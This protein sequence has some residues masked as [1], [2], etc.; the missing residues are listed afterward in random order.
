[1]PRMR[2]ISTINPPRVT[3]DTGKEVQR[4]MSS[5]KPNSDSKGLVRSMSDSKANFKK[6]TSSNDIRLENEL[7]IDVIVQRHAKEL[8]RKQQLRHLGY[9][10]AHLDFPLVGW[11]KKESSQATVIED[12]VSA[13][14]QLHKDFSWPYPVLLHPIEHYLPKSSTS[15]GKRSNR[16]TSFLSIFGLVI[17]RNK[18]ENWTVRYG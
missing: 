10:A 8:L 14:K 16:Q 12:A 3:T 18:A 6:L 9:F 4:T 11:F 7:F 1:M 13:L 2:S 5:D 17:F 15:P